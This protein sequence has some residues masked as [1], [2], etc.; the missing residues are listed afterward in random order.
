MMNNFKIDVEYDV[1][2]DM[3]AHMGTADKYY[4]NTIMSTIIMFINSFIYLNDIVALDPK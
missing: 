2:G 4:R 3:S 1:L